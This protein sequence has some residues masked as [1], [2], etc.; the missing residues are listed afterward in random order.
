MDYLCA[1]EGT[2]GRFRQLLHLSYARSTL[3]TGRLRLSGAVHESGNDAGPSV[4]DL[5]EKIKALKAAHSIEA[6]PQRTRQKQSSAEE[7]VTARIRRRT[8]AIPAADQ[9]IQ[10]EAAA[11]G[12]HL[13]LVTD[14]K[15]GREVAFDEVKEEAKEVFFSQLRD[16]LV[17]RIQPT[18]KILELRPHGEAEK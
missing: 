14:R 8:E 3:V 18:A 1:S 5:A 4:S 10:P 16:R 13:I 12:Y 7:P 6:T 9:G 15:P 2:E 11:F 17:T